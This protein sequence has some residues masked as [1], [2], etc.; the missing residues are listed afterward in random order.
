MATLDFTPL[1][2]SSVGFDRIPNLLTSAMAR[3]EEGFPPY[4]IEKCGEDRYRIVLA[5]AGFSR[6]DVEIVVEQ[7]H[8]TV[9]GARKDTNGATYVH[10]GVANR[11]FTRH[12]EL[13]DFIEVTE[14]TMGDGLLVIDLKREVP[15]ALKPR[16]IPINAGT[17]VQLS[18]K[19][20]SPSRLAPT[21]WMSNA[22]L[23]LLSTP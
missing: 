9:R 16:S 22:A 18:R 15:E 14:A 3:T 21:P 12:F 17:F 10:R 2:R 23:I 7:N 20:P 19:A 8:L 13:A 1:F 4:N 6:D 5:L 11:S